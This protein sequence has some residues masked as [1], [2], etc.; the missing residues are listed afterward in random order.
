MKIDLKELQG[1]LSKKSDFI[2]KKI[3]PGRRQCDI[4]SI[5][6]RRNE[7]NGKDSI[8]VDLNLVENIDNPE[9]FEGFLVDYTDESKGRYNGP[10]GRVEMSQYA[11]SDRTITNRKTGRETEI[12][13]DKSIFNDLY[14]LSVQCGKDEELMS[15]EVDDVF[16]FIDRASEILKGSKLVF[17]IAGKEYEKNGYSNYNLYLPNKPKQKLVFEAVGTE[18]SQLIKYD[19]MTML[20]EK[21][22]SATVDEFEV[23]KTSDDLPF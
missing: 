19:P 2:N 20:V 23:D 10:S 7:K 14:L 21:E 17:I 5:T 13:R 16:D 3:L 18:N 4:F 11:Y 6:Y 8:R 9:S 22:I 1:D 15:G 12:S